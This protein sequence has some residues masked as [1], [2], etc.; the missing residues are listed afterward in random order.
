MTGAQLADLSDE[1]LESCITG[2]RV[3]A[4]VGPEQ[5]IRIVRAL[6]K[7]GHFVAMTGDG[8]NDAPALKRSSI[9]VAMGARGTEVARE[10][11]EMVLLDDNF[12]TIVAAVREGR[13]IFDDIRKFVKYALTTNSGE[14][15][16]LFLAPFVGL[17][18]PLLPLHILWI[19]LIT[20]GLPGLA[21]SAEPA[22]PDVMRRPPRPPEQSIFAGGMGAHI[23]WVGFVIGALTLAVQAWALLRGIPHWQTMVFTVLVFCQLFHCLAIRSE[24]HSIVSVGLTTNRPLLLAITVTVLAQLAVIYTPALNSI[25]GTHPLSAAE[26]GICIAVSSIVLMVVEADKLVRRQLIAEIDM[27]DRE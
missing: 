3:Y 5:K 23:I 13:R 14:I 6:Q 22:E 11:A 9:G 10:A 18:V 8:V 24:K 19:N 17:P 4:R 21:L 27:P 12:A 7:K 20:D 16:V 25:F 1:E 26:L 2:K 15:W